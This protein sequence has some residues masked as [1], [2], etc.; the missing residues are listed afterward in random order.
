MRA[1]RGAPPGVEVV[2]V[3]EPE[4]EGEL[5]RVASASVCASDFVYLG[6]GSRAV[7]GHEIAG[8]SEAGVAV[9]VEGIFG[10][11][12]CAWCEAGRYNRC[13]RA[14]VDILGVTVPGGMSTWFRAPSRALVPLPAGLDPKDASLVEPASVAWHAVQ[15]G[16]V[17]TDTRTVVVGA[18]AIGILAGIIAQSVGAPEVAMA[19]RHPHQRE[20]AERFGLSAPEGLYDVAIETG[21]SESSLHRSVELARPGGTMV[22]V[23]VHDESVAWPHQAAFAKELTTTPALGYATS[24]GHPGGREFSDA[25]ALLA[26]RP[27][28]VDTLI[29]HRFGLEDAAEAFRTAANKSTGALRVVIHP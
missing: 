14:T 29:T 6:W 23:G 5:I 9:A 19:A 11:G 26:T 20:V 4:G 1:V 15:M 22:V 16:R 10:C 28:V 7:L 13:Q 18:G 2:D 27:D 24:S 25:A 17:G 21:G 8:V 3:D 12:M